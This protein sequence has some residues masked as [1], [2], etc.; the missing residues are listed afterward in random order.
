MEEQLQRRYDW[1]HTSNLQQKFFLL[2]KVEDMLTKE[3]I[4]AFLL[5]CMNKG[6]LQQFFFQALLDFRFVNKWKT[7]FLVMLYKKNPEYISYFLNYL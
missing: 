4:E 6:L 3:E 1:F 2:S 5:E 7:E